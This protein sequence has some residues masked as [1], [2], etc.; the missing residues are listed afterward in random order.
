MRYVEFGPLKRDVDVYYYDLISGGD[1]TQ[2]YWLVLSNLEL[3]LYQL[4]RDF[5]HI[6]RVILQTDNANCYQSKK[7]L[8]GVYALNKVGDRPYICRIIHTE[9]QDGKCSIDAHFVIAMRHVVRY[10][11]SGNNVMTPS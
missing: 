9:T 1:Q 6:K 8:V 3:V 11:N 7:L 2:D 5:P 4:K 10:V